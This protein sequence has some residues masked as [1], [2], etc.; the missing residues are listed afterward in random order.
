MNELLLPCLGLLTRRLSLSSANNVNQ[1]AKRHTNNNYK[2]EKNERKN[3]KTRN[4][5]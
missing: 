5:T 3:V 4:D 1:E 2:P